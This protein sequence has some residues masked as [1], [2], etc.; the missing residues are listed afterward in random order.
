ML[1]ASYEGVIATPLAALDRIGAVT[2]GLARDAPVILTGGG[3]R[4]AV[5]RETVARLSGR[6]VEIPDAQELVALGGAVQAA[7]V[8]AG[9]DPVEV[10]ERWNLRAGAVIEKR[11]QDQERL[12]RF[13]LTLAAASRLNEREVDQ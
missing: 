7:A 11:K 5:W 9:E 8:L 1:R 3:A 4:G 6:R 2:P 13:R 12:E 10:A